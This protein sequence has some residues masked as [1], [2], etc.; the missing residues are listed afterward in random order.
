MT[1][2]LEQRLTQEN[3]YTPYGGCADFLY[4]RDRE[5][6][7]EGPS[8][9]GKTLAACWKVHIWAIKYPGLNG[10]IVRNT[11]KSMPGSVLQTF[12]RVILGA[13]VQVYGGERPDKYLYSNG[14]SIWIGGMDNPDKI[15]SSERDFVY[16]NQAEELKLDAWEKLL[17][18]TTGRGAIMPYTQLLGDCNPGGS[19]HWIRDRARAGKLKLI[20][21]RHTD[22]PTLYD[23]NGNLTKHGKRTMEDLSSLTG[24]RRKRLYEG[25]WATAEGAVY[26]TFDANVHVMERDPKEFKAWYLTLDEGYTNPAVILVVG[27]DSDKRHHIHR[28][29]Y[30]TGVIQETVVTQTAQWFGEF[31]ASLVTVDEA[32]A[33]LIADL[34]NHNVPA[35][36]AKGRVLDRIQSVQDRLKVQGDGRP[37]L[38]IDPSCTGT[39][40]DFE[41]RVWKPEKDEPVKENDHGT[42]AYEYLDHYLSSGVNWWMS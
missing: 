21:T 13:P 25:I 19:R 5:V 32:A 37:R 4:S 16:V 42:D 1:Y 26:D 2:V 24:V 8:E 28:E 27:E 15:L 22:N 11:Y 38:T 34:R 33:G 10:A 40:N 7:A 30:K 12:A 29:F 18:R 20:R 39:I 3:V 35:Q 36:A 9:T 23:A 17:T 31:G 6:I 14:S 41:S